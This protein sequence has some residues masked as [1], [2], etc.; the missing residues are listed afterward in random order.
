[1]GS[2]SADTPA[3][4]R[5]KES[6]RGVMKAHIGSIRYCYEKELM[7]R[8]DIAGTT[9]ATFT[10][11]PDGT[12]ASATATGFDPNVDECVAK[13]VQVLRFAAAPGATTVNYPF[14]FTAAQ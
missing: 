12:V 9:L 8:P 14:K 2:G 7:N 11:A 13:A 3:Q 6:I 1:M 10:I 4:V 5:D